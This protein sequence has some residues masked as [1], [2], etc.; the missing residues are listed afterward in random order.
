VRI[1]LDYRPALRQ[2][3]GVGEY[4]HELARAL[5]ETGSGAESL[6]LF[7]SSW[8][9]RV[10]DA[11]RQ[12]RTRNGHAPE[13]RD[14][15][16]P[17]RVLNYAWHRL[18]WPPVDWLQ[19]G[20]LDIVH[21]AHPLLIPSRMAARLVTVHDLDF[22]DHPDRTQAEIRRD[23]PALAGPHARAADRVIAVSAHTA[24]EVERRLHVD[25]SRISICSPGHPAWPRRESEPADG[26]ILFLGTLEPR[27][28]LD[29]LL[30]AYE[31]LLAQQ[32]TAPRLVLAGGETAASGPIVSRATSPPLAGRVELPGYIDPSRRQDLYLRAL[33]FVLPSHTEGFGIPALEAMTCGVPVI[34]ANRGALPEVVG[35]AGRLFDP[36]DASQLA[37][38]LARVLGDRGLRD[39]LREAGWRQA[40]T[41]DWKATAHRVREA[42][43][44]ALEARRSRQR[45]SPG[46]SSS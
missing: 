16:I 32:P 22:L 30:E 13:F 45:R 6:V 9:D 43:S 1:L 44:L 37:H 28:N 39:R 25:R 36:S 12:A 38:E 7:S 26:C 17:V 15:R 20:R 27:K 35:D 40:A 5:T 2:R 34:V 14:W 31:R 19:R 29:V 8:K 18:G 42:W 23:Y 46:Q 24:G 11:G 33:V 4:V 21:S 10:P 41:F 3:S